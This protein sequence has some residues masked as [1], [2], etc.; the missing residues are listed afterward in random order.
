[1]RVCVYVSADQCECACACEWVCGCHSNSESEC[2]R[3]VLEGKRKVADVLR[4]RE[5]E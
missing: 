4:A 1:M 3:N 5:K 2:E